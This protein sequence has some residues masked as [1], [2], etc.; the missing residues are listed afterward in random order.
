SLLLIPILDEIKVVTL[1]EIYNKKCFPTSMDGRPSG[2]IALK[3][4]L[5]RGCF[6]EEEQKLALRWQVKY[7]SRE[8]IFANM[9]ENVIFPFA[10]TLISPFA[11]LAIGVAVSWV[12]HGFMRPSV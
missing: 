3:M 1:P 10:F 7:T 8:K 6:T 4:A 12:A 11:L 5:R 9:F 2:P